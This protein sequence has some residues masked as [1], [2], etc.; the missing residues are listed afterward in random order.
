MS[1]CDDDN[2]RMSDPFGYNWAEHAN[3]NSRKKLIWPAR[4]IN[5][6]S[7]NIAFFCSPHSTVQYASLLFGLAAICFYRDHYRVILA[8]FGL[9]EDK[10]KIFSNIL[11]IGIRQM[12][13]IC[14]CC[15]HSSQPLAAVD[16]FAF[17][18]VP[19]SYRRID[20]SPQTKPLHT[21]TRLWRL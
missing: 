5:Y 14:C 13:P 9:L 3:K 6:H 15:F 20:A 4:E 1:V 19:I 2:S 21:H 16:V 17:M 10:R 8:E 18:P 11:F 7:A 12:R